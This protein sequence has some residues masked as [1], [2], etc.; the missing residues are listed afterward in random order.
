MQDDW[1]RRHTPPLSIRLLPAAS[2]VMSNEHSQPQ[3]SIGGTE[4]CLM[5]DVNT[6]V[7]NVEQEL[8][9]HW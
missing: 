3:L 5:A 8:N 2:L 9:G 4:G 1:N 7:L 6:V